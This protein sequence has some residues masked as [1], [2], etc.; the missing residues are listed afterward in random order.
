MK[1]QKMSLW[2]SRGRFISFISPKKEQLVPQAGQAQLWLTNKGQRKTW[3]D[4]TIFRYVETAVHT[5][6]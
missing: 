3:A 2:R 5:W 6:L 4:E 1:T